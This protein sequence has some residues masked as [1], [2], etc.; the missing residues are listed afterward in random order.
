MSENLPI[1]K[2]KKPKM[3]RALGVTEFLNKKFLELEFTGKWKDAFG[4]PER[5]FKMIVFGKRKNGKT[6]F[7]VSFVK[8]MT[9]FG[10]V[11]YNSF[12]QGHSRSLQCAYMRQDMKDVSG[13]V[14]TTHKEPF[15]SMYYR[16]K[17]KKS[18]QIVVID[19]VQHIKMTKDQWQQLVT[20]FP[21]KAFIAISHAQGDDPK[22]EVADFI[23][24]DVD[25]S[26]LVK[27]FKAYCQGRYGGGDEIVI[28]EKGHADYLRRNSKTKPKEPTP[29]TPDLFTIQSTDVPTVP[30]VPKDS[31]PEIPNS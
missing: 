5:N 8:F 29:P 1:P 22:G 12:E 23:G 24:Y 18:P 10:R 13:K 14:V 7:V 28:W 30:T 15:E 17:Q 27:G 25:I 11:L 2:P 31:A 26:V 21:K 20:D 16:L 4:N 9:T 6:E 19:S 3:A